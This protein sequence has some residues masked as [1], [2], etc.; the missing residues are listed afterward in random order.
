MFVTSASRGWF[1]GPALAF[2]LL[3]DKPHVFCFCFK[4]N[5][6]TSKAI[7]FFCL[8][9]GYIRINIRNNFL[10]SFVCDYGRSFSSINFLLSLVCGFDRFSSIFPLVR[11]KN[12]FWDSLNVG[13]SD[14][15]S[16][17]NAVSGC[18]CCAF[19]HL[20]PCLP[21]SHM[22]R[23]KPGQNHSFS[24]SGHSLSQYTK[25]MLVYNCEAT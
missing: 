11:C 7:A 3:F 25:A 2:F 12:F 8:D 19:A 18:D 13:I 6:W 21:N 15:L 10:L 17:V 9:E 1:S 5:S 23:N 20:R 4:M 24:I 14:P 22:A 16:V